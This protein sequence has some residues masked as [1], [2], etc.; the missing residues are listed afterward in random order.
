MRKKNC[1]KVNDYSRTSP[2]KSVRPWVCVGVSVCVASVC[3]YTCARGQTR[4]V[5][6]YWKR[7]KRKRNTQRKQNTKKQKYLQTDDDDGDGDGGK[8]VFSRP[9]RIHTR[10]HTYTCVRVFARTQN[11]ASR[12]H[13]SLIAKRNA[14]CWNIESTES[15]ELRTK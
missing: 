6:S 11:S 15:C 7:N 10:T 5:Y 9:T 14:V 8:K 12:A 13:S 2:V 1:E 4:L 3:A